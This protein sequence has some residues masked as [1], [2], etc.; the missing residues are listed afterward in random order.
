MTSAMLL[1][2]THPQVVLGKVG[3]L[4]VNLGSPDA[5][6]ASAVRKYL[7][8]FLSDR[9]VIELTPL[10]WQPI[11]QG[12][13]L[14]VRP[15]KSAAKY[16]SVWG[17]PAQAAPLV[18]ITAEQTAALKLKFGE[19]C[20]VAFAMRYGQPVISDQLDILFKE[21]GCDRIL[22]APLY[23]QYCA[24]TTA[25]II[26]EVSRWQAKQRWQPALRYL[27]P[28]YDNPIYIKA[29]V[30]SLR[31]HIANLSWVPDKILLSFHGMPNETLMKGDPYHCQSHKSA[32]LIRE[33]LAWPAEKMQLTFQSRFGPKKWL[34]PYTDKTLEIFAHQGV[35]K[36]VVQ[37]PGFAAD[38]LETL[39]EIAI[40]AKESFE[41]AGGS[42]YSYVPCLNDSRLGIDMLHALLKAELAG[43]IDFT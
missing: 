43:W 22:I 42:H 9:R 26:D 31:E 25:S 17:D 20:E 28:Y 18:R 41:H 32:R 36:I 24:A 6:T 33:A 35:K 40:E 16:A 13:I 2:D 12:I 3:V 19:R 7:K 15:R 8:Q 38:C 1:T 5:P 10:L 27:P 4:L 23:P 37:A 11:L 34:E 21:K 29:V 30:Q 39:E 14:N